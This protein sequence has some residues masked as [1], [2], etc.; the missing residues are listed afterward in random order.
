MK[1]KKKIMLWIFWSICKY[2][3][4]L[5]LQLQIKKRKSRKIWNLYSCW[6]CVFKYCVFFLSFNACTAYIYM[7]ILYVLSLQSLITVSYVTSDMS[8]AGN[9]QKLERKK[10]IKGGREREN[11]IGVLPE[12]TENWCSIYEKAKLFSFK[13]WTQR[14]IHTHIHTEF[15]FTRWT[16]DVS[17]YFV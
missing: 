3:Y 8:W 7:Y 1:N 6:M 12:K 4:I 2:I 13:K 16:F 10:R 17:I 15:T 5:Q 9:A 11:W 14:H